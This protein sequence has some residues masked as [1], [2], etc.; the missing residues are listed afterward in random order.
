MTRQPTPT[1]LDA[2]ATA[3]LAALTAAD[4]PQGLRL[5]DLAARTGLSM[6]H[7]GRHLRTLERDRLARYAGGL[8]H[9]TL[10]GA[11]RAGPGDG[12]TLAA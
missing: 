8:W 9:A 6:G 7:I 5:N 10:R 11:H 3:V 2:Q 12:S 4:A 1:A